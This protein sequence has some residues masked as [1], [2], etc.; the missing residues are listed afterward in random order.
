MLSLHADEPGGIQGR[1]SNAPARLA[2]ERRTLGVTLSDNRRTPARTTRLLPIL[3]VC[4]AASLPYVSSTGNYF[5]NDDFGV[6][7]LLSQKPPLYFPTWFVTSWMDDIWGATQ[8]EIRPFPAVTYQLAAFWGP[9]STLANHVMNVAVHAA[10]ALLVLAIARTV[11]GVGVVASTCAALVFAVLPLHAESVVWITGRVDTIP[12]VFFLGSFLTYALWRRGDVK[13]TRLYLCSLLLFF[14]ALFSK[15]N[16]IIMVATLVLYDFVAER[17][18]IRA[19]WSWLALYVP[20][21]ALTIGY[22]LLRYVLFGEA[23]REGHLTADGLAASRI[24]VG[25]HFQRMFFGGEVSRYP[26][27]YIVALLVTTLSWFLVRSSVDAN[28]RHGSAKVLYFGPCWWCLNLAPLVVVGYE[29]TR[30]VYLASVGWAVVVG[31]VFHALWQQRP[32]A[33]R[34]ATLAASAGLFVFYTV[35][36]HAAV[37][38]WKVRARVSQKVVAD[39]EREALAAPEGSLLIVGA[40]VRSW[41]WAL[42]FAAQP[43]FTR[44]DLAERVSIVSP[45]LIDCCRDQWLTRTQRI[46]QAWSQRPSAPLVVLTWDGGTGAYS[47][48]TDREDPELRSQVVALIDAATLEALDRAMF[49]ILRRLQ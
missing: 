22:L 40:P 44:M 42:P 26:F 18:P 9:T 23:V 46:I 25:K 24:F 5:V 45:V 36:L 4:L 34:Y 3:A 39:L 41:E 31:L 32:A 43:P 11:A 37:A 6:V 20:F 1:G 47:R 29:S 17:R 19:S 27:G 14:C 35:G 28:L 48:L 15:Q 2:V 33:F 8:D 10:N 21:A 16:T 12:A 7:Q 49:T 13:A 30:H 38:D